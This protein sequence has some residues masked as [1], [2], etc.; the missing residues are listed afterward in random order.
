MYQPG[1]VGASVTTTAAGVA[2]LPNTGNNEVL[3]VVSVL[4]IAL[5]TIA[6][7]SQI[8]VMAYRHRALKSL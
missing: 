7:V 2:A 6:T 8:A 5:G 1:G 4:A 3:F